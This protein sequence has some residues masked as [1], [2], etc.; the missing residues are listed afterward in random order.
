VV[1]EQCMTTRAPRS[2]R[3]PKCHNDEPQ[4]SCLMRNAVRAL[5]HKDLTYVSLATISYRNG[6][7]IRAATVGTVKA[8]HCPTAVS[9]EK[10]AG[11]IYIL[12][13]RD[14]TW[15]CWNTRLIMGVFY[16]WSGVLVLDITDGEAACCGRLTKA[17]RCPWVC[18]TKNAQSSLT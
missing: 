13:Q 11:D 5:K 17:L 16:C 6:S 8:Q 12:S 1:T 3:G 2:Y 14:R 4:K 15:R 10:P 18:C 9:A 7:A